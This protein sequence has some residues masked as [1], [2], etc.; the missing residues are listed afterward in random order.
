M[1]HP[2]W[3]GFRHRTDMDAWKIWDMPE[4]G[5][6]VRP[7]FVL[8]DRHVAGEEE[9]LDLHA[10]GLLFEEPDSS[11]LVSSGYARDWP[12]AR[13][14]FVDE[15]RSFAAFVNELDH[16]R[17]TGTDQS[18]R[19]SLRAVCERV[20]SVLAALEAELDAQGLAFARDDRLGFL[21]PDPSLLGTCL[22]ASVAIRIPLLS[23][24]PEL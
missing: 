14:V 24:Q 3:S 6:G 5:C 21:G 19:P 12:D 17:V 9:E 8:F 16:L 13:G 10:E 22:T 15:Q 4:A 20:F 23:K 2:N 11:V 1:R 18:S 7:Q